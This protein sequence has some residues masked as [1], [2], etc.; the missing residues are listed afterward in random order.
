[1]K[2]WDVGT[3][4]VRAVLRGQPR[5][6]RALAFAPA[7]AVLT[8]A[9]VNGTVRLW[10][11]AGGRALTAWRGHA[12]AVIRWRSPRWADAGHRGRRRRRQALGRGRRGTTAALSR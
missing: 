2:L 11:A 8:T 7:G 1:M 9:A 10:D 12:R 4:R 5:L 3:G 6:L